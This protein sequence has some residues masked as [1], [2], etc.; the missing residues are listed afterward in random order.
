MW[1]YAKSCKL[2]INSASF[3]GS[4]CRA[5]SS[6]DSD[7]SAQYYDQSEC[8]VVLASAGSRLLPGQWQP[9][10]SI[11]YCGRWTDSGVGTVVQAS[12]AGHVD[13]TRAVPVI[14]KNFMIFAMADILGKDQ[15]T[16]SKEHDGFL[17]DLQ[18]FHD[19]RG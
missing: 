1:S 14:I 12:E 9:S 15:A 4:D 17:R 19:T 6:R 16:Y 8:N 3:S 11:P 13:V 18:H 10:S 7:G 2:Y 5:Y